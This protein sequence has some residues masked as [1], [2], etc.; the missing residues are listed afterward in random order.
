MNLVEKAKKFLETDRSMHE[1]RFWYSDQLTV[2]LA[3][4]VVDSAETI[5]ACKKQL[6]FAGETR[7][8]DPGDFRRE[9]KACDAWIS[10]Y[11]GE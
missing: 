8:L 11:A 6:E 2:E 5:R 7:P 3:Q 9:V 10:R 1:E 4:A